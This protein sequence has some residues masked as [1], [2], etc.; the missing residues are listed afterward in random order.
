MRATV[1]RQV[2]YKSES[3]VAKEVAVKAEAGARA[4]AARLEREAAAKAGWAEKAVVVAH[5]KRAQ[6]ILGCTHTTK[7][8]R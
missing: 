1:R 7:L 3:P 6:T 4:V 5:H 2:H 8:F